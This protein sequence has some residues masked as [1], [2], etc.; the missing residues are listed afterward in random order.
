MFETFTR[1]GGPPAAGGGRP[2]GLR[3]D[4]PGPHPRPAGRRQPP[5]HRHHHDRRQEA[6]DRAHY[7]HRGEPPDPVD[8]PGGPGSAGN[9]GLRRHLH[10]GRQQKDPPHRRGAGLVQRVLLRREPAGERRPAVPERPVRLPGADRPE[11]PVLL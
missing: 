2:A 3:P 1:R 7:P 5:A 10:R 11:R 4:P 6:A 8:R 9:R